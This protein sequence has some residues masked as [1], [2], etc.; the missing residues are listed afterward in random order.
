MIVDKSELNKYKEEV[1]E[2]WGETFAYKEYV[3]KTKDY[4]KDKFNNALEEM[5]DIFKEFGVCLENGEEPCS[6]QTQKLVL[7]L[8]NHLT[9]NY[10]TCTNEVLKGLGIMYVSDL[11]FKNNID[12]YSNGASEYIS[13]AIEIYCS[14]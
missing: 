6:T 1:K 8:Q 7:K 10:Y 9:E 11:R 4:S 14:R 5:I 13:K 3:I 2:K 12:K